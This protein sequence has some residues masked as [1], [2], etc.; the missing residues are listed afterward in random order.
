[1]LEPTT[2]FPEKSLRRRKIINAKILIKSLIYAF[3]IFGLLFII[4]LLSIIGL[5]RQ[6]AGTT[7]AVPSSAVLNINFNDD[8]SEIRKDNLLTEIS[9]SRSMAFYDLIKAINV[10]AI[11]ER[12]KA[13]FGNVSIS[14]LGIAQIQDLRRAIKTFQ[15]SGKKAYMFSNGFGPLGQGTSEYYLASSFDEIYMQPNSEAGITGVSMEVPF[16]RSLLNRLGINP[17]FYT[18]Y[19]YKTAAA[20]LTEDKMPLQFKQ[21][22]ESLGGSIFDQ[23]IADVSDAR[24][25]NPGELKKLVNQAPLSAEEALQAKLIDGIGYQQDVLEKLTKEYDAKEVSVADYVS[26]FRQNEASKQVAF[27][28]VDGTIN[29]GKS[30]DNPL[31]GEMV[32]GSETVVKQ[33]REIAENKHVKALVLRVNSPGGSYTASNEIWHALNK[34]KADKQIPIIVSMGNYAASG[35]YFVALA[36]DKI[37]AAPSTVTGS[38]GVL[39]GKLVFK[40]LWSKLDINWS[41]VK[42]GRNAGILSI[43]QNFSEK[44]KE[45]FNK[46]LDRIYKDFTLK[47]SEARNLSLEE[48][49]RLARGRVWSGEEA[50]QNKLVDEVGGINQALKLAKELGNIGD[51]ERYSI[52]YYPKPKTLQEKIMEVVKSSPSVSIKEFKAQLGLENEAFSVLQRLQYNLALP[53]FLMNI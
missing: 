18:R 16:I 29:D 20:S 1:M 14:G 41:G 34:F 32:A 40:D 50:Y 28:V 30:I 42:F 49:D 33:L 31:S 37:V 6:E 36:G 19:E 26:N 9:E 35:G 10:A 13:I 24:G 27:L 45:L 21:Q 53:P 11:D 46:S 39:G 15:E 8:Y 23:F 44:E 25:I 48:V 7:T 22:L 47:V 43:N 3:A 38:I 4:F 12:V 5:L 52:T 17:E 51:K 2:P